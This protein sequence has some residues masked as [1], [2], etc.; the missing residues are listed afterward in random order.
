LLSGFSYSGGGTNGTTVKVDSTGDPFDAPERIFGSVLMGVGG[1]DTIIGSDGSDLLFGGVG[2]DTITTGDPGE[3]G[4]I[5]FGSDGDDTIILNVS[6]TLT[7]SIN[8][9]ASDGVDDGVNDALQVGIFGGSST[10]T[11]NL[12]Q[13]IIQN[14]EVL[15]I[16]EDALTINAPGTFYSGLTSIVVN[17][18]VQ[19]VVIE[20]TGGLNLS[21]VSL[22]LGTNSTVTTLTMDESLSNGGVLLDFTD[23]GGRTLN[24]TSGQDTI[25]GFRGADV[26]NLGSSDNA[27]DIVRYTALNEGAADL[28]IANADDINQFDGLNDLIQ[29]INSGI[30]LVGVGNIAVNSG[31]VNM[32]SG[33]GV[34]YINDA[35]AASLSTIADVAGA[36]G[37]LTN[38]TSADKAV[39]VVQQTSGGPATGVYAFTD[40]NGDATVDAAE[41]DLL[42]VV[43]ANL[44]ELNV[45]VL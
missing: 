28:T 43:D 5:V 40:S 22:S 10:P 36:I 11:Y 9:G 7:G 34:F 30:F 6:G 16:E 41:L 13:V 42:A 12:Q 2:N 21:G 37:S 17:N 27:S 26:I 29:I 23:T 24:G 25:T 31:S 32:A 20:A 15:N 35:T 3:D 14:I 33:N 39:F 45:S 38:S 19:G 44:T 1:D 8:G 4:D 18:E